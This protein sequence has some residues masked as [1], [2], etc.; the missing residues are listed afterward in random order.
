MLQWVMDKETAV[1]PGND[2]LFNAKK[3]KGLSIYE[4]LE[5]IQ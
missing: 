1:H 3:K 4:D 5:Y 2:I